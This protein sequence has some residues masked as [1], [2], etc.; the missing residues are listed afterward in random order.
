MKR[1]LRGSVG[2]ELVLWL[3]LLAGAT[4][5]ASAADAGDGTVAE[6]YDFSASGLE[7][8]CHPVKT[9]FAMGEPQI[10][11]CAITNTTD[12]DKR[13]SL[14]VAPGLHFHFSKD[15]ASWS[16]G[17]H[18]KVA[19]QIRPPLRHEPGAIV[20]PPHTTLEIQFTNQSSRPGAF[21]WLA[22]YDPDVHGGMIVENEGLEKAKKACV[23]SNTFEY[24]VTAA[25]SR[26]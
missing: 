6:E 19:P 22:V 8:Q 17:F 12:S 15:E 13:I 25:E 23:F 9:N 3:S 11:R 20:L 18:P 10:F 1:I 5:L 2:A 7:M 14:D 4:P 26:K 16:T 21:R 24:E